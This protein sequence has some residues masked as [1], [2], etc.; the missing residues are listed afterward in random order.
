[1]RKRS[2]L[3][4]FI[5]LFVIY[6]QFFENYYKLIRIFIFSSSMLLFMFCAKYLFGFNHK[7]INHKFNK[8]LC[9]YILKIKI[10]VKNTVPKLTKPHVIMSNHYNVTDLNIIKE[11][12]GEHLYTIGKSDLI[13][14]ENKFLPILNY[15]QETFFKT[16]YII[17]YTRGD[18][19]SGSDVKEK[20][21]KCIQDGNHVLIFPEGTVHRDGIPKSFKNGIF[22]LCHDNNIPILPVT[23]KFKENIGLEREDTFSL[24]GVLDINPDVIFH[25]TIIKSETMEKLRDKT[26]NAIISPF[27][28][29]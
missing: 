11:A 24:Y 2:I 7:M 26:F 14:S 21:L 16:F 25:P 6:V 19:N 10:N 5:I 27:Q 3:F 9:D 4:I 23:I 22:H 12:L 29:N 8:F 15:L 1:M 17:P 18:K 13:T 28:L 20:I